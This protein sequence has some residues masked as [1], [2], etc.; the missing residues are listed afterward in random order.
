MQ[1]FNLNIYYSKWQNCNRITN[2]NQKTKIFATHHS[3]QTSFGLGIR[4]IVDIVQG[5]RGASRAAVRARRIVHAGLGQFGRQLLQREVRS[6][7][8]NGTRCHDNGDDNRGGKWWWWWML[9]DDT[10][11]S[12][13]V[14]SAISIKAHHFVVNA[15][16]RYEF[17]IVARIDHVAVQVELCLYVAH[18]NPNVWLNN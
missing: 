13:Q 7:D 8:N 2:L 4:P 5:S 12:W 18:L 16:L 1:A 14:T 6:D 10:S 15:E 17:A 9:Y 3:W 11:D